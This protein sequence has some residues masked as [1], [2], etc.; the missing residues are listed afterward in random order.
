MKVL[1]SKEGQ[2]HLCQG[3]KDRSSTDLNFCNLKIRIFYSKSY[4]CNK[5]NFVEKLGRV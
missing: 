1:I 2:L 5:V 3:D 4:F